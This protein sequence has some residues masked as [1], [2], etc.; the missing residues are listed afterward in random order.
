[1]TSVQPRYEKPAPP[2]D[3]GNGAAVR[4][5]APIAREQ[6]AVVAFRLVPLDGARRDLPLGEFAGRG[7]EQP[8]LVG[9]GPTHAR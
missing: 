4:P 7:L 2:T 3:V 1:M 8:L 5:S 6:R 9:Q